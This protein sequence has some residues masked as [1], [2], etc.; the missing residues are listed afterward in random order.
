MADDP[1]PH[2]PGPAPTEPKKPLPGQ[3]ENFPGQPPIVDVEKRGPGRP[4][5]PQPN[6]PPRTNGETNES[7]ADDRRESN[8]VESPGHVE[9]EL[10]RSVGGK[11]EKG[12]WANEG[13]GNKT[14]DRE[15][16]EET[17]DFV[18]SGRVQQ[19]AQKAAEALD[20][21]EAEELREAEQKGRQGRPKTR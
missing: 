6:R 21:T 7:P 11:R 17:E 16:R 5:R 10:P 4:M 2:S 14:A 19:Q 3:D 9:R 15:Y 8:H 1:N 12:E 20:G 18:K 13:E